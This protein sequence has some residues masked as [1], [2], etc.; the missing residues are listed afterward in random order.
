[1]LGDSARSSVRSEPPLHSRVAV[2]TGA[3]GGIGSAI[4]AAFHDAGARVL[5][6]DLT[7]QGLTASLGGR[8]DGLRLRPCRSRCR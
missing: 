1:M 5:A 2:V 7:E 8:G 6:L 4:A 3:A